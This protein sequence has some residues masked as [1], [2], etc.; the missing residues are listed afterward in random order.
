MPKPFVKND[1]R[2]NRA[3]RPKKGTALTDILSYKLDLVHKAGK[4][5]REAIAERLIEVA[6]DGDVAALKYVFDRCSN[7]LY[8][9]INCSVTVIAEHHPYFKVSTA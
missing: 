4:M 2:I 6:L 3:G 1:P 7:S 8:F 5:K 9:S